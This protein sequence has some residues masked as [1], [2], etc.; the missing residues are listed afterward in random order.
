M[1]ADSKFVRRGADGFRERLVVVFAVLGVGNLAAWVWALT[2]LGGQPALLGTA[3]LAYSLGLRH[4]LDADHIAAIDNVTRKLL[5]ENKRPVAVGFFFALGHSAVLL[6]ASLVVGFA[7]ST[8]IE[9]L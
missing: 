5:Q 8:L 4:A 9:K 3:V 6:L 7:A 2:V 1:P